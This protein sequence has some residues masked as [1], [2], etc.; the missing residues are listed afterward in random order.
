M[1]ISWTW[2]K[3]GNKRQFQSGT[4]F[5]TFFV[6]NALSYKFLLEQIHMFHSVFSSLTFV[7]RHLNTF[8]WVFKSFFLKK[9]FPFILAPPPLPRPPHGRVCLAGCHLTIYFHSLTLFSSL[10]SS[11]SPFL[12]LFACLN[13]LDSKQL[14]FF[15][16]LLHLF[17]FTYIHIIYRFKLLLVWIG[18][19]LKRCVI[20]KALVSF[21]F[22]L[23]SL[24]LSM[25]PFFDDDGTTRQ[26]VC[27]WLS[28]FTSFSFSLSVPSARLLGCYFLNSSWSWGALNVYFKHFGCRMCAFQAYFIHFFVC[29]RIFVSIMFRTMFFFYGC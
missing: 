20:L 21:I 26:S 10:F 11:S 3:V 5:G 15:P 19:Q 17:L 4:T 6:L 18:K 29:R 22:F 12:F 2:S 14:K 9:Y 1:F 7:V 24:H 28:F 13:P 16:S 23:L 27:C 8:F 25:L